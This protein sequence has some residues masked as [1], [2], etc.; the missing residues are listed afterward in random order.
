MINV[1]VTDGRFGD[2]IRVYIVHEVADGKF[3]S[4]PGCSPSLEKIT[5]DV[6]DEPSI[7]L[8]GEEARAFLDALTRYYHGAEDT[9]ALRRDYDAERARVDSQ[10]H[11]IADILR[12]LAGSR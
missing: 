4:R 7:M 2:G 8:G 1:H 10:S 12:Q 3:I 6:I 11:L 9:R 5:D